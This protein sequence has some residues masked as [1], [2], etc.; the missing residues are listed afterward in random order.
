MKQM[1]NGK[2]TIV[3]PLTASFLTPLELYK[4]WGEGCCISNPKRWCTKIRRTKGT[5]VEASIVGKL[6]ATEKLN[7]TCLQGAIK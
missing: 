3:V 6:M 2:V 1:T 5:S 7:I 4:G